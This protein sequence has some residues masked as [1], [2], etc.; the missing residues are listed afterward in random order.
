[1][2]EH[3]V[4]RLAADKAEAFGVVKPLHCSLFHCVTCL[5]CFEFLL[6][7]IAAGDEGFWSGRNHGYCSLWH[8]WLDVLYQGKQQSIRDIGRQHAAPLEPFLCRPC[9]CI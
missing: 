8:L 3:I 9:P 6:R 2:N 5:Y 7:R 1:M 4:A